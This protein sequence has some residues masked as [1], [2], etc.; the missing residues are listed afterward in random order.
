MRHHF[1]RSRKQ[2][3]L[4]TVLTAAVLAGILLA[5]NALGRYI[6]GS[7][8]NP[9]LDFD[10][11]TLCRRLML[12]GVYNTAQLPSGSGISD[13]KPIF[14]YYLDEA[15]AKK[16]AED[17]GQKTFC[18]RFDGIS[19]SLKGEE[20]E[21]Q[22]V[23]DAF[24]FLT[25]AIEELA[26]TAEKTEKNEMTAAEITQKINDLRTSAQQRAESL[27]KIESNKPIKALKKCLS[28]YTENLKIKLDDC[29]RDTRKILCACVKNYAEFLTEVK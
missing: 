15:R 22:S 8:I 11:G 9:L 4:K 12:Y 26:R 7:V 6:A 3:V 10:E 18:R 13:E 1:C 29:R 23:R 19:V 5:V 17:I 21:K 14:S 2:N 25:D 16:V 20:E 27:D 24:E 28:G